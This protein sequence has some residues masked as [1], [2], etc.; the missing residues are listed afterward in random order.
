VLDA[1]S[2]RAPR[3]VLDI[4]ARAGLSVPMVQTVLGLFELEDRVVERER[5]WI[6]RVPKEEKAQESTT[7]DTTKKSDAAGSNN[8]AAKNQLTA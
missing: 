5:G 4:A 2:T 6:K 1:L 7:G 3:T 8:A